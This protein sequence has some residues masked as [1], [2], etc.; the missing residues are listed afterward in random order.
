MTPRNWENLP[1]TVSGGFRQIC[2]RNLEKIFAENMFLVI[3]CSKWQYLTRKLRL[4]D[5]RCSLWWRNC[6]CLTSRTSTTKQRTLLIVSHINVSYRIL[7]KRQ[8]INC[9]Q[10]SLPGCRCTRYCTAGVDT[11]VR[12]TS[13]Y[14]CRQCSIVLK[15]RSD[16]I[17]YTVVCFMT[18]D[19]SR[20]L[21]KHSTGASWV[22]FNHG[23][24]HRS[25]RPA[26]ACD[27]CWVA[28]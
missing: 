14:H 8:A 23:F 20:K 28:G 25:E 7:S 22:W 26:G 24:N 9:R 13:L 10:P 6:S 1:P 4:P 15:P 16:R 12:S 27:V 11:R 5:C 19:C 21:W 18:H 3:N 2:P 17:D